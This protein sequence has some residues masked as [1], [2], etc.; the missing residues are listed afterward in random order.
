MGAKSSSFNPTLW[1]S[2]N[3]G[4]GDWTSTGQVIPILN[5]SYTPGEGILGIYYSKSYDYW[6]YC[7]IEGH[8]LFWYNKANSG[9]QYNN[10]NTTYY[11]IAF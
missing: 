9:Y 5:S 4:G 1:G 3:S 10:K 6:S 8:T 11:W 2:E 7:K